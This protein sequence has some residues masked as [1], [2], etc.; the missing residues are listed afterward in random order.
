MCGKLCEGDMRWTQ[1]SLQDLRSL[2]GSFGPTDITTGR[3][4][5]CM[6]GI[7]L[8]IHID[9]LIGCW[10]SVAVSCPCAVMPRLCGQCGAVGEHPLIGAWLQL[11]HASRLIYGNDFAMNGVVSLG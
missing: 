7:C 10:L 11:H 2:W 9:V 5:M 4:S 8:T 1:A 6:W 3:A